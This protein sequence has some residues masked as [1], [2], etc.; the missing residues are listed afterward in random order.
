MGESMEELSRLYWRCRRG[1]LE[2]DLLLQGFLRDG[3]RQLEPQQRQ[4]FVRLLELPDQT[5]FD[6]L[7]GFATVK[8]RE[9]ADVVEK[10]RHAAAP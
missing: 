6:Y 5:L 9:F 1:M 2:L 3:Y 8:E 4:Q 7:L 10:I